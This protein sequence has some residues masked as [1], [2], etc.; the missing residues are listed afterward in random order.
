MFTKVL[1]TRLKDLMS[2][3]VNPTKWVLY[4][5]EREKGQWS[6]NALVAP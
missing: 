3:L 4:Q 6:K 1:E 2:E 5:E